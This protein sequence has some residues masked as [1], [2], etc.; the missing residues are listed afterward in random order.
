MS[1]D[2]PD[3]L[4][5]S[6]RE[7]CVRADLFFCLWKDLQHV[8]CSI[9]PFLT[10]VRLILL[11]V[12]YLFC[13]WKCDNGHNRFTWP[14]RWNVCCLFFIVCWCITWRS[15]IWSLC[16]T[17]AFLR[18]P[19][20][21]LPKQIII[22]INKRGTASLWLCGTHLDFSQIKH[23]ICDLSWKRFV[24]RQCRHSCQKEEGVENGPLQWK[25]SRYGVNLAK[26]LGWSR[27]IFGRV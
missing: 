26:G 15:L 8:Y 5:H 11:I 4:L 9:G 2:I 13:H 23:S 27:M 16:S 19:V 25:D 17:F 20:S 7:I 10:M 14:H 12:L 6:L 3:K 24:H 21:E 22:I 1:E 18:E